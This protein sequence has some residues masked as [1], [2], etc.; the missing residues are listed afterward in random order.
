MIPGFDLMEPCGR[1]LPV[2]GEGGL[3]VC[4]QEQPSVVRC[5]PKGPAGFLCGLH[6]M[7][8]GAGGVLGHISHNGEGG[9]LGRQ[10]AGGDGAVKHV[11][12]L[13]LLQVR[14][15]A[16]GAV[17]AVDP[18]GILGQAHHIFTVPVRGHTEGGH[19]P[20]FVAGDR[21]NFSIIENAVGKGSGRFRQGRFGGRAVCLRRR[22]RGE[23]KRAGQCAAQD[24]GC[25]HFFHEVFSFY[26]LN[27]R[28]ISA[29]VRYD[30]GKP[31]KVPGFY[32]DRVKIWGDSSGGAESACL[33]PNSKLGRYSDGA[34]LDKGI[35]LPLLDLASDSR[36]T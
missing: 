14:R 6:L 15:V 19:L 33:F 7:V 26:Y 10:G 11:E 17:S 29:V 25:Q 30:A 3:L 8:V 34:Y 35:F 21:L 31:P 12:T 4:Q 28:M 32:P 16:G 22:R 18:Y 1:G 5:D 36:Y 20:V 24:Q 13:V 2:G 23:R 27:L 9:G